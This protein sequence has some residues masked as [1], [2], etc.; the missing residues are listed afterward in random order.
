[1]AILNLIVL[2]LRHRM[3]EVEVESVINFFRWS[4]SYKVVLVAVFILF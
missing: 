3:K 4:I 1:M 2:Q